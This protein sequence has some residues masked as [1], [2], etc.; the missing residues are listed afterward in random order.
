[1]LCVSLIIREIRWM[2]L[3]AAL[4]RGDVVITEGRKL[5]K[6]PTLE[7]PQGKDA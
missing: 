4:A 2:A 3:E 1:M 5:G 6:A 7:D